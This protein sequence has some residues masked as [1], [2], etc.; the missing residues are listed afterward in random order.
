[1]GE[2]F[3]RL[4]DGRKISSVSTQQL[5]HSSPGSLCT[6]PSHHPGSADHSSAPPPPACSREQQHFSCAN[7]W[8]QNSFK[9]GWVEPQA[10]LGDQFSCQDAVTRGRRFQSAGAETY[11][12]SA[13][14]DI[15]ATFGCSQVKKKH[16]TNP[17][18]NV[19][20]IK[21]T[22]VKSGLSVQAEGN[23]PL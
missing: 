21:S 23:S 13:T 7:N 2:E 5:Q 10:A 12:R 9:L 18:T 22:A 6:A 3:Q 1:M 15:Q 19:H 11:Q 16:K 14:V 4:P 20:K 17:K 8:E